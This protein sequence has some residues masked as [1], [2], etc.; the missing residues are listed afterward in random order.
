MSHLRA[1]DQLPIT[2][3]SG[4]RRYECMCEHL[5][6]SHNRHINRD[7]AEMAVVWY[8]MCRTCG[9]S[10]YVGNLP[11]DSGVI[12]PVNDVELAAN[13]NQVKA[14]SAHSKLLIEARAQRDFAKTALA[15]AL[16]QKDAAN[17]ELN[18]AHEKALS[19]NKVIL[20]QRATIDAQQATLK[21]IGTMGSTIAADRI[22]Y[23]VIPTEQ[24]TWCREDE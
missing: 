2:G 17:K 19:L 6:T 10:G 11:T 13:E 3:R 18:E 22:S 7:N 9:C 23:S 12:Y 20:Q 8:G 1:S 21:S 5:P 16:E 14:D 24:L 4:H 15:Q